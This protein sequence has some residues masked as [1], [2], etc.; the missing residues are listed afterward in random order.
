MT[1]RFE[2]I[3]RE[4]ANSTGKK[5]TEFKNIQAHKKRNFLEIPSSISL[6]VEVFR[7]MLGTSS[8][9]RYRKSAFKYLKSVSIYK[10]L[11]KNS[12]Y[13][14]NAVYAYIHGC[15]PYSGPRMAP[16]CFL[17]Y[18]SV[19]IKVEKTSSNMLRPVLNTP[20]IQMSILMDKHYRLKAAYSK[21]SIIYR[22]LLVWSSIGIFVSEKK[23]R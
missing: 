5:K 11:A 1:L 22:G 16:K 9:N 4:T 21:V 8:N 12:G 7:F 3:W 13:T 15:G 19:M 17:Y 23:T 18:Y 20:Y 14:R 10:I 2:I 6:Q